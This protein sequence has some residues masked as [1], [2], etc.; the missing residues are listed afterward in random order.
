MAGLPAVGPVWS[1]DGVTFND[2]PHADTGFSYLVKTSKGW[3]GS[4]TRRPDNAARPNAN[5]L[6]RGPNYAGGR[7]VELDGIA[8][9]GSRY[10]RDGLC[11]TL[12]GLCGD[13][14]A[15]YDLVRQEPSRSLKLRVELNA[16][17][18]VLELPDGV[19]VA[20][21]VQLLAIDGRKFDTQTEQAST[22]LAQAPL[23]GVLWNGTP[24]TTG[25]EWQGPATDPNTGL[26]YQASA[27]TPGLL[28]CRN[29]GT[30]PAPIIFT[31]TCGPSN[32]LVRPTLI[33]TATG[34]VIQYAGTLVP[35]DVLT[36]DTG[37]GL[38]RLNGA[39]GAGQ[40]A[41]ADYFDIPAR[42]SSV[43]QF[44]AAGPSPGST[45]KAEWHSA[46]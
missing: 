15:L 14:F 26:V 46:Y 37:T 38:V 20:F 39:A 17:V 35:G 18:S 31:I 19:T 45:A 13:P 3:R 2:G 22:T 43:V 11:D 21:N 5:G 1:L 7:V 16:G 6:Y 44:T 32:T 42:S 27:G 40:L 23:D 9:A 36:V 33:D 30:Q 10:D 12:E 29:D 34:S 41:R 28:V 8:Q 25:T 24:G 4:P